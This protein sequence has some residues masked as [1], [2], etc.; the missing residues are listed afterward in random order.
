MPT[1]RYVLAVA[2]SDTRLFALGGDGDDRV[3]DTL[4][5]YESATDSWSTA[6]PMPTGRNALATAIV[7][8]TL[9]AFGGYDW[10]VRVIDGVPQY[11]VTPIDGVRAY[12]IEGGGWSAAEPMG[13]PRAWLRRH[14]GRARVAAT[15]GRG[16]GHRGGGEVGERAHGLGDVGLDGCGAADL[17]GACFAF[18][19][20]EGEL[21][22]FG[23]G[24]S[25]GEG[26]AGRHRAR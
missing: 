13:T 3:L 26:D 25:G 8:N 24:A 20:A 23:E 5:I 15:Q 10:E 1:T 7:G 16:G 12:E 17:L 21:W 4:E 19:D 2:A 14:L 18:W 22:G 6:A 9:F 11:H